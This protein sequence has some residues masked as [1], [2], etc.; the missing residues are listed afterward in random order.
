MHQKMIIMLTYNDKT[1]SNALEIFDQCK[2]LPVECWGFKNIG[3]PVENMKRL[4]L[5]M[6]EVKKTTFLEVVTYNEKSCLDAAKLALECQFDYFMGTVYFESVHNLLKGKPIKYFPFCGKVSS[7]PSILENSMQQII[8]DAKLMEEKGVDGFDLLAYRYV[9]NA[10]K[11]AQQFIKA[12][13]SPVVLAG[14]INSFDRLDKIKQFNPWGFTIG[15]A[16]FDKIFVKGGSFKEQ[17]SR[18][19][20]YID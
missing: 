16:F 6:K 17:I 1:V 18:V 2:E 9:E 7:S 19:L 20:S 13:K 5:N 14:S 12:I 11:L 8:D 3:L 4:I 15:S 10:E